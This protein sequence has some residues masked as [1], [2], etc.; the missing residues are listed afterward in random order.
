M[1]YVCWKHDNS[2]VAPES[3]TLNSSVVKP[4]ADD[5]TITYN[6]EVEG[7][8]YYPNYRDTARTRTTF[9]YFS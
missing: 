1:I 4:Y 6:G 8:R 9:L 2:N 5:S 3:Y 7:L